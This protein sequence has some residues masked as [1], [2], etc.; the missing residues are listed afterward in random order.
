[1]DERLASYHQPRY[2]KTIDHFELT[3]SERIKK[4]L[5]DRS[6]DGVWDRRG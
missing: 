5:L 4:H 1:V 2:Y 6:L 3:P